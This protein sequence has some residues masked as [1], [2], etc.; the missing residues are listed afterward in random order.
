[1][2]QVEKGQNSSAVKYKQDVHPSTKVLYVQLC[3]TCKPVG[4]PDMV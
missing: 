4:I 3:L 2:V 1:M